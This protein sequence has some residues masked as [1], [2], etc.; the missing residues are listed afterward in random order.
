MGAKYES[1]KPD[2]YKSTRN[3]IY[4]EREIKQQEQTFKEQNA[5]RDLPPQSNVNYGKNK[6]YEK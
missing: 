6:N 5:F 1:E 2:G 4:L 3:N